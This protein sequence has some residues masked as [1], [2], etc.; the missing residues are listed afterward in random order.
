MGGYF[1]G[2]FFTD[3]SLTSHIVKTRAKKM[4]KKL[5]LTEVIAVGKGFY[6]LCFGCKLNVEYV[7]ANG[8]WTMFKQYIHLK[9]WTPEFD[10]RRDVFRSVPLWIKK[11]GIL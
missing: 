9:N 4:W 11:F 1:G 5:G 7:K 3:R 10:F 8:P 6:F 2:V